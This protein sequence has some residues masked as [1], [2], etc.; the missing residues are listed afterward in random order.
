M[1]FSNEPQVFI[2]DYSEIST[3]PGAPYSHNR[4]G[5]WVASLTVTHTIHIT[6]A[7]GLRGF[8]AAVRSGGICPQLFGQSAP[9]HNSAAQ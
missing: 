1:A 3:L 2:T 7:S 4:S 6:D 5:D 9:R 8:T